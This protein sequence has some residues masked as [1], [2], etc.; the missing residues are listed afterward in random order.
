MDYRFATEQDLDLLA[1]WNHQL[2]RDEG[3]ENPMTV[4]ELRE[5]MKNWIAGE[6]KAVVFLL[7]NDPV[8]YGLYRENEEKVYLRQLFVR[9]DRRRNGIGRQAIALFR[10]HIWPSKKRL[11]V[12]VLCKN[13]PAIQFWRALG[14][15]DYCLTLEIRP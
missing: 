13:S 2:I 5:R 3:H 9:R 11:T 10:Q 6:Y 7:N 14:Y 1:E 4:A 8:A 12:D 15:K